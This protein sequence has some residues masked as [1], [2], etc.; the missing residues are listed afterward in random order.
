MAENHELLTIKEFAEASGRSQ[1]TIYK[2]ISTRLAAYLHEIDG[3]KFIEQKALGE[4]F[5]IGIQ[6]E[7][8]NSVN[9]VN[10]GNNPNNP[11]YDILKAELDAKNRQI[12]QLQNQVSELTQANKELAQSINAD[13][14]NELAG[15][16]QQFLPET[17]SDAEI[18][19]VDAPQ[20][21]ETGN[22]I[23]EAPGGAEGLQEAVK[24]LSWREIIKA[25]FGRKKDKV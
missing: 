20:S 8:N 25:K 7:E 13:R 5:K 10:S 15:T 19:V 21:D 3:Q 9:S 17:A 14:K 12:E 24:G 18:E 6:P 1:Q 11:L 22:P 23:P 16:L 2:Q 4:V